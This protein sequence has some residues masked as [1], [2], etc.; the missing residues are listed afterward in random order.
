MQFA[1]KY[2]SFEFISASTKIMF[3]LLQGG[4]YSTNFKADFQN[5]TSYGTYFYS[6]IN[7][8]PVKYVCFTVR[9]SI[10]KNSVDSV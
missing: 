3:S 2:S 5:L 4:Y 7:K 6:L 9:T 10:Y 8:K 1:P